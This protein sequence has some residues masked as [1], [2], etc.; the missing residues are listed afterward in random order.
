LDW[1]NQI[2]DSF[3]QWRLF[4]SL[5]RLDPGARLPQN[6]VSMTDE[7]ANELSNIAAHLRDQLNYLDDI[8]V[9]D[10]GG[11]AS[12]TGPAMPQQTSPPVK[13]GETNEMSDRNWGP[14]DSDTKGHVIASP[15]RGPASPSRTDIHLNAGLEKSDAAPM[16][17][18]PGSGKTETHDEVK[19]EVDTIPQLDLFGEP[20][21]KQPLPGVRPRATALASTMFDAL[22]RDSSL[23]DIRND[24]G[25]C[26]RCKLSKHRTHIV[27]GE[28]NPKA[29]LVFVGEGPGAEEDATGRPFVG[30]AGKLLDKIIDAMGFN[31]SDVYICNVVKCRPPENRTPERDEA[32]T[33]QPFLFRQL[34]LI[35]P[36]VVVALGAPA[37]H[38]LVGN[39][40]SITRARGQWRD[41]N[42]MKLIPT[43]HPAYLLRVPDKKRE[44]WEDVKKVR[45]Y[46]ASI[47]T[48]LRS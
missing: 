33:C 14:A 13:V 24:I 8:G 29:D 42:G 3:N 30:R 6:T 12:K 23:E 18:S 36:K 44:A 28:G 26:T 7:I 25:D 40:E 21:S 20:V 1:D 38:C 4:I 5:R 11:S 48:P 16:K 19:P 46:L 10:I 43:Y 27:F 35:H 37:L 39:K 47:E 17:A 34:A 45:D 22:P 41:W 2:L 15:D 9:T 32:D 31:R